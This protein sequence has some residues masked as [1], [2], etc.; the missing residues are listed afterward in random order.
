MKIF[1][2]TSSN[3]KSGGARQA[4]FLARGLAE[5]GHELTFFVPHDAQLPAVDPDFNWVRLPERRGDWGRFIEARLPQGE[6]CVVHAYHN[7]AVKLAAW[8]G[9]FWRRRGVVMV[10]HRGVIYR[11]NNPLPYWSW[12]LDAFVVNSEACGRVLRRK[13]VGARRLFVVYNG[14]PAERVAPRRTPAEVRAELGIG[15]NELILGTVTDDSPNKGMDLLIRSFARAGLPEGVRLL[16]V[17][18]HPEVWP[19]VAAECG[20]AGRFSSVGRTECVADYLQLFDAFV[21]ASRSESMPNTV[22]EALTFGLPVV[23]TRVGGVPE[24]VAGNGILVPP[25]DEA[26]LADALAGMIGDTD[27]REGWRAAS[28]ALADRFSMDRKVRAVEEVYTTLLKRRGL[29]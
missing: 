1:F 3:I 24:L 9:L 13:G 19:P 7:K 11:P 25:D 14:I 18:V 29:A 15:A 12:G 27:R 4:H 10:G 22:L 20:V 5:R 17:G 21:L 28:L 2:V 8:W 16:A 26:A 6:P 23:A